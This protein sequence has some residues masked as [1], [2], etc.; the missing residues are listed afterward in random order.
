MKLP[1]AE[2]AVVDIAKLR[3]YCLN[4]LHPRGRYKARVFGAA[5]KLFQTDADFLRTQLLQAAVAGDGRFGAVDQ[6]GHRYTVDFECIKGSRRARVRSVWI[7]LR[8]EDFPRLT[9]CYVIST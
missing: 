3:E 2:R 7:I 1:G 5:L 6:Y 4:P 8:G 9:T